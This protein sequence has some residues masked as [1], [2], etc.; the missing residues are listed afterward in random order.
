M[1]L[2][3]SLYGYCCLYFLISLLFSFFVH[4]LAECSR[5]II[6][7]ISWFFMKNW[8][9]ILKPAAAPFCVMLVP[10]RDW[11]LRRCLKPHR[12]A[13]IS[14]SLQTFLLF[15]FVFL[16][17]FYLFSFLSSH[18]CTVYQPLAFYFWPLSPFFLSPFPPFPF[19]PFPFLG[20]RE[21]RERRI[22]QISTSHQ[23]FFFLTKR[24]LPTNK[25]HNFWYII[26]VHQQVA[27]FVKLAKWA[28][29]SNL[30]HNY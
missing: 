19:L 3:L 9:F 24:L 14:S 5:L 18:R 30:V 13:L 20:V 28:V 7:Y 12:P 26:S 6:V 1:S 8:G 10:L 22:F 23:N 27:K 25:I 15:V 21:S 4:V 16:S 17:L 11:D 29:N 2:V